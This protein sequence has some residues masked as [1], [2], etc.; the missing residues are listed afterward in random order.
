MGN[1]KLENFRQY[2]ELEIN[3]IKEKFKWLEDRLLLT[4]A[5]ERNRLKTLQEIYMVVINLQNK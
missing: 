4:S 3:S 5:I 1:D 2:L